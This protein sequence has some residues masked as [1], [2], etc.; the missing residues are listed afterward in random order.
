MIGVYAFNGRTYIFARMERK[1]ERY[2]KDKD[3]NLIFWG[4]LSSWVAELVNG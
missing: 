1:L 3:K 4:L 2:C